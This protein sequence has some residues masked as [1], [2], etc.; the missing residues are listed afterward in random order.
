M[1]ARSFWEQTFLTAL[2][3]I[4]GDAMDTRLSLSK[5]KDNL[6]VAAAFAAITADEALYQRDH[7]MT[8]GRSYNN[9]IDHDNWT[10]GPPADLRLADRRIPDAD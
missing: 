10:L 6:R 8:G 4:L 7:F 3:S 1:D 2:P 5:L 9:P